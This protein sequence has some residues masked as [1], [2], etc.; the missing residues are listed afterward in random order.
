MNNKL[1]K[2]ALKFFLSSSVLA[3]EAQAV[4]VYDGIYSTNPDVGYVYLREQQGLMVA[5]LNQTVNDVLIW[6]AATGQLNGS[7][8]H[9]SSIIGYVNFEMDLDFTST[10]SFQA[11][12][13]ACVPQPEASCLFQNGLA[14]I[15][16]KI[17]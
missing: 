7:S 11:T 15:G 17:W 6:A 14:F 9:L 3:T 13:K 1:L 2:L 8:V 10:S 5:V 12:Q 4:S 16:N